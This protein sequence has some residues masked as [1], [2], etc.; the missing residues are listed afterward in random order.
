MGK[1]GADII[2]IRKGF[3]ISD[4]AQYG[5]G[6][7]SDKT[8]RYISVYSPANYIIIRNRVVRVIVGLATVSQEDLIRVMSAL[9]SDK[10]TGVF[11][12]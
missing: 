11:H 12:A 3:I 2:K 4:L 1:M 5:F 6:Q 7:Y 9:E 10:V 8:W